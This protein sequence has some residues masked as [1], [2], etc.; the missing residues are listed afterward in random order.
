[1]ETEFMYTP[2]NP[3]KHLIFLTKKKLESRNEAQLLHTC[4]WVRRPWCRCSL[5][6]VSELQHLN[7]GRHLE[8]FSRTSKVYPQVV[9]AWQVETQPPNTVELQAH[10]P[11]GCT[12]DGWPPP[13]DL[14]QITSCA[15]LIWICDACTLKLISQTNW[16]LWRWNNIYLDQLYSVFWHIKSQFPSHLTFP[17]YNLIS[18]TRHVLSTTY[19]PNLAQQIGALALVDICEQALNTSPCILIIC[20]HFYPSGWQLNNSNGLLSVR[21]ILYTVSF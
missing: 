6:Q 13:R 16:M 15:W 1:M 12:L 11:A 10:E 14:S 18:L 8:H 7:W 9:G 19:R 21:A 3:I 20:R 2:L 5:L 4:F 17:S